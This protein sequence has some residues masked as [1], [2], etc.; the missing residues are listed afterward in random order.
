MSQHTRT[1]T[2]THTQ[3]AIIAVSLQGPD[4]QTF[5]RRTTILLL[6][7]SEVRTP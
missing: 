6:N 7:L 5:V 3:R 4:L 2:H 1:H